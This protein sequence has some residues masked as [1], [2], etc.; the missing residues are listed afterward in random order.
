MSVE[1]LLPAKGGDPQSLQGRFELLDF[2][3]GEFNR[4]YRGES[5]V[6]H[7][8][9]YE[10][11]V[12]MVKSQARS[13]FKLEDEPAALRDAYGRNR[14]GQGCLL[15][16]RLVERDVPFVEVTLS[17]GQANWDTHMNNFEG[18]KQL[19]AV[20][21]PAWATLMTDLKERGLLETTLVVW[22]GNSAAP[23]RSISKMVAITSR[24]PGRPFWPAAAS[25]GA[26]PGGTRA[27]R[28]C[29][30]KNTRFRSPITWPRSVPRHGNRPYER[31]HHRRGAADSNRR[32]RA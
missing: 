17:G 5:A 11:A 15:A 27:R 32:P 30:W 26:T 4:R 9:N 23:P 22:M 13:A 10:R 18:V 14:F 3:H 31:E 20:L 21:D 25:R 19:S 6:S 2:V 12:R 28:A 16:R 8:A 7:R 1:N 24:S 29:R